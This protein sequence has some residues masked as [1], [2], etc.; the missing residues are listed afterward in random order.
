MDIFM[1]LKLLG[2]LAL[3]LYGMKLMGDGLQALASGKMAQILERLTN[4]TIYGVLLGAGVTAVIQSSSATTVMVISFVNSG[5]MSLRQAVGVIMGANIGTT[6]TSWM[7]SMVGIESDAVL[8]KMLKPSSFAPILAMIGVVLYMKAKENAKQTN[9]AHLLIGF[10]VLIFGMDAMSASMEPLAHNPY[11]EN[12]LVAVSNPL[13]G[14]LVGMV[15][16]AIIQSSSASV[17]ILQALSLTGAVSFG[18]AFPII[19]GQNIGTCSTALISSVG[20]SKNARRASMIHLYFNVVGVTVFTLA[21]YGL[22]M[23]FNFEFLTAAVGPV[24]IAVIHSIFNVGSTVLIY[25]FSKH[26]VNLA[27]YTV[28]DDRVSNGYSSLHKI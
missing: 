27:E 14:I 20:A 1:I 16:T 25:P 8:I 26:L 23:I 17:G 15:F 2:G 21:F 12:M 13:F 24:T 22:N 9:I 7:L 6:V 5:I 19:L 3:F 18:A 4:K 28:P 11:F 10:S